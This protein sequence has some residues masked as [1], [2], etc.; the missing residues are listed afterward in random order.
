VSGEIFSLAAPLGKNRNR[1][2]RHLSANN[3]EIGCGGI[4]GRMSTRRILTDLSIAELR[5]AYHATVSVTGPESSS[6][7]ALR[8]AIAAKKQYVQQHRHK[9]RRSIGGEAADE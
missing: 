1:R 3:T 7:R 9:P 5:R 8:R 4:V 2:V 6:A